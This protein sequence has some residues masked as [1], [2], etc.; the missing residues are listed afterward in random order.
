MMAICPEAF[1]A[2]ARKLAEAARAETLPRFR[3]TLAVDVKH[4]R[5][6]VTEADRAAERAIRQRR[7]IDAVQLQAI[8]P[9]IAIFFG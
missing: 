7:Q 1:L 5:T 8:G 9:V 6:P 3:R 4:D 2:F